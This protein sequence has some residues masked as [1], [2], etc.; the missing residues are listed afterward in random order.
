MSQ[1][2]FSVAAEFDLLNVVDFIAQKNPR[3]AEDWLS[4]IRER[5]Q[6]LADH[7]SLVNYGLFSEC[8]AAAACRL[9]CT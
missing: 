9:G 2:R 5:C 6:L 1:V 3:A 7:P 8:R 4:V